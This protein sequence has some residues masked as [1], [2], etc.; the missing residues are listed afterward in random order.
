MSEKEILRNQARRLGVIRPFEEVTRN[1]SKTCR[2]FGISRGVFYRWRSRYQ[3]YGDQGLR[4]RSRRPLN[5][6]RAT[7]AEI[8]AKIIYLRERYHFGPW[9]I[10][11][12]LRRYHDITISCT[13]VYWILRRV[14]VNRLPNHEGQK[15]Y[16]ER[17]R[18]DE[19]PLPSHR[20]QVDVA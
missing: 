14:H 6:P 12:Y 15:R 20:I 13:G 7:R 3:E 10:Q 16:K 4:D 11:M 8:V 18:I 5:S 9:K 2:Y 1:I 19:K 17:F